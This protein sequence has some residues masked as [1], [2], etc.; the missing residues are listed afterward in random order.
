MT[1]RRE[2][3]KETAERW[4]NLLYGCNLLGAAPERA[5]TKP[6]GRRARIVAGRRGKG[7]DVPAHAQSAAQPAGPKPQSEI[8][9]GI[10]R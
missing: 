8:G 7:F 1:A 9:P 6:A 4:P 10:E 2:F 5:Q 3:M